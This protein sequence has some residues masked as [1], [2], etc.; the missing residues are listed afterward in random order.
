MSEL[1]RIPEAFRQALLESVPCALYLLDDQRRVIFWNPAA[2]GLTGYGPDEMIG[3]TCDALRM[4]LAPHQDAE[5]LRALCSAGDVA[6]RHEECE[7]VRRDGT[8]LPIVRRATPVTDD[9]GRPVGTIVAMVDVSVIKRAREEISA[10]RRE[11]SE[12]GRYG[13]M[14]GS[15]P[16]MRKLFE[17]VELVAAT[18]ASVVIEGETGTGKELVARTI[19]Q[20]SGRVDGPFLAVNC[21]ALPETLLEA[22]LFGHVAGA[23]TGA[24]HDR[25]GRFEQASGGTLFLDEV[26]ELSAASQV[27][28]LRAVQEGEI[29][30]V[31]ESSPR[32]VDTRILAATHRDLRAEVKAGRFRQDLYYRLRVVGLMVPPLRDRRE[33]VPDLVAHFV[34]RLNRK[35][36]RSVRGLSAEAM[37][38]VCDS[39]W[40][41]NVRQLEHA[42]EHAFA[43][44]PPEA[45][46]LQRHALPA[47]LSADAPTRPTPPTPPAPVTSE[48]PAP[49]MSETDQV[50]HALARANGNKTQAARLLGITRAGLYKKLKRLGLS[51]SPQPP[52]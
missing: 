36:G 41:G 29:T 52:E 30:R 12:I 1:D 46:V 50:R 38:V 2:E 43:V 21:G 7:I 9:A 3:A 23:F 40:P 16:A 48:P 45:D 22:E 51:T 26:G 47:D 27:K 42:I 18:D 10:L 14:I 35:Y 44:S 20:R 34:D 19:H 15:S 6:G 25:A 28:L 32:Q 31:G 5:V 17:A 4:R 37:E 33:D 8:P 39:D 13:R 24:T 49:G 11:V